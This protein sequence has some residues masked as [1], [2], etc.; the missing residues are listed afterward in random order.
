MRYTLLTAI[1]ASLV[2]GSNGAPNGAIRTMYCSATNDYDNC[3][4]G[5]ADFSM[6]LDAC[7]FCNVPVNLGVECKGDGGQLACV[8][9]Y[10]DTRG[11]K[12]CFDNIPH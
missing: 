8:A 12:H 4:T 11:R 5:T 10:C 1:I 6:T 7:S 3:K 2:A 9:H